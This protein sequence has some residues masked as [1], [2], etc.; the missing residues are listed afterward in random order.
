MQGDA[1]PPLGPHPASASPFASGLPKEP[2]FL[3]WPGGRAYSADGHTAAC[4]IYARCTSLAC[5]LVPKPA[6][7]PPVTQLSAL[8]AIAEV[9]KRV[10]KSYYVFFFNFL[11]FFTL[12]FPLLFFFGGGGGGGGGWGGRTTSSPDVDALGYAPPQT[13]QGKDAGLVTK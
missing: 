9:M 1:L 2:S 6:S 5:P 11:S 7:G 3:D 10:S 8:A 4:Y 13:P 12:F